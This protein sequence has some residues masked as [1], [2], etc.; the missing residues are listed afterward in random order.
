[1]I[2]QD[3]FA[4]RGNPLFKTPLVD[5]KGHHTLN[6]SKTTLVRP[7][8]TLTR[9]T[10]LHLTPPHTPNPQPYLPPWSVVTLAR[11]LYLQSKF[12]RT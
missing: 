1:M 7:A 5:G 10:S 9:G 2:F 8:R 3:P 4:R 11:R 12:Q 6:P